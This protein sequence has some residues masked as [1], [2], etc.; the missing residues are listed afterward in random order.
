MNAAAIHRIVVV[1]LVA[2]SLI[3]VVQERAFRLSDRWRSRSTTLIRQLYGGP[4]M[5]LVVI[6]GN[7]ALHG[8][9]SY[10]QT[11]DQQPTKR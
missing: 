5:P 3:H 8:E 2:L 11:D 4:R 9:V 10:G 6:P 1:P 7:E